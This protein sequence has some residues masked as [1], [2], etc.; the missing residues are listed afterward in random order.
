MQSFILGINLLPVACM[1][2]LATRNR[3]KALL[4]SLGRRVAVIFSRYV[5][6]KV[7][8][9]NRESLATNEIPH[10]CNGAKLPRGYVGS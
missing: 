10:N 6:W 1:S 4:L 7:F 2:A 3:I 5:P 9:G 8:I